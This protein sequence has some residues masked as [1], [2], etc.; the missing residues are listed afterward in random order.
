MGIKQRGRQSWRKGA[1]CVGSDLSLWEVTG[2]H[3]P[4]TVDVSMAMGYC[5][6]C[7][8]VRQCATDALLSCDT[9]VIRAGIPIPPPGTSARGGRE[10]AKTALQLVSFT[11]NVEQARTALL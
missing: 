8:V 4:A 7:P 2:S 11:G 1:K 9:G 5:A 3:A 10:Q 6:N